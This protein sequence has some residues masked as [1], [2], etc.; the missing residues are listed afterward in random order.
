MNDAGS[1][2]CS[3]RGFIVPNITLEAELDRG[4]ELSIAGLE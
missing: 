1:W 4:S 3:I 2:I